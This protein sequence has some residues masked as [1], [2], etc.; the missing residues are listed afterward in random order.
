MS[1]TKHNAFLE[2][3]LMDAP[4]ELNGMEAGAWVS[5]YN[6]ALERTAAS[7]VLN[8]LQVMVKT[9]EGLAA[10]H[11]EPYRQARAAIAK[12]SK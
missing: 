10:I 1:D 9:F 5:G 6:E 2:K 4:R 8:A 11:N 7:D 12:A 3:T